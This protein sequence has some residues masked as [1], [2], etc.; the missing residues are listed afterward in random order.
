MSLIVSNK[1]LLEFDSTT[2]ENVR[3]EFDLHK[4]GIMDQAIDILYDWIQKQEHFLKKDFCREYLER[5]IICCKGSVERAKARLD[6]MCTLRTHAPE[7][8]SKTNVMQEL[9]EVSKAYLN[10]YM[11]KLTEKDNYRLYVNRYQNDVTTSLLL[12]VC[13]YNIILGEY[14]K[15]N[16]Y[17]NGLI[18]VLD[19]RQINIMDFVAQINLVD[20]SNLVTT[21]TE[22]FGFRIKNIFVMST[23]KLINL[24]TSIMK[25]LFSAKIGER[26]EVL[27][28]I[29]DLHNRVP[30]EL[31]P[32]EYGGQQKTLT[33]LYDQW[34]EELSTEDFIEYL[35]EMKQ[36]GVNESLRPKDGLGNEYLGIPGTFKTINVD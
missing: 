30:K 32:K 19:C 36:A 26:I 2:I 15:R 24:L 10:V 4:P 11:P 5:N 25:Q 3:K 18:V 1:S 14:L 31:L 23:S 9:A 8:F 34:V 16:D 17:A 20:F 28:T 33:E 27:Q 6:K 7:L 12:D 22:G 29:E 13:R 21:Y 35:K